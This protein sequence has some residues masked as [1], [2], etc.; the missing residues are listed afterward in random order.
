M[1]RALLTI[2][3]LAIIAT[4]FTCIASAQEGPTG[5]RPAIARAVVE[6][7]GSLLR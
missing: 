2:A 6:A 5:K 7:H 4:V 3:L 1:R